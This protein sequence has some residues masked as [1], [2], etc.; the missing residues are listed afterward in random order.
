MKTVYIITQSEH[1]GAQNYVLQEALESIQD[2]Q[3]V[4]IA[5][6]GNGWLA[7]QALLENI[8][9]KKLVFCQRSIN[10]LTDLML[11]WEIFFTLRENQAQSVHLNSSKISIIGSLAARLS[12]V[13]KITY[14]VHGWVFNEPLSPIAKKLYFW[15]EK[16][17]AKLKTKLIFVSRHDLNLAKEFKIGSED[18]YDLAKLHVAPID[19]LSPEVARQKMFQFAYKTDEGQKII[20]TIANLYK[21]KALHRLVTCATQVQNQGLNY[22]F[23]II[24][25]GP[26]RKILEKLIKNNHLNNIFLVG[27]LPNAAQYLKGFNLFILTSVKEGYPYAIL[28]AKEAGIPILSTPAGGIPEMLKES[29]LVEPE[30]LTERIIKHFS[31]G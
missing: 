10:P 13:K 21:T 30:D 17:T 27:S 31:R 23:I 4:L 25:E 5:A 3:D 8:P 28:E 26:E 29:E 7:D 19:F 20:G 6:G 9:Y 11:F 2:N 1:G 12:G 16:L 15:A 22:L 14:T 24:G 18:K